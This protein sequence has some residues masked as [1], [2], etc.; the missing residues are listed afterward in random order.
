MPNK[1]NLVRQEEH[2][3]QSEA[4]AR[5][6]I[7]AAEPR[8]SSPHDEMLRTQQLSN[9]AHQEL[10]ERLSREED[11]RS[12]AVQRM[13]QAEARLRQAQL[14]LANDLHMHYMKSWSNCVNASSNKR[15]YSRGHN[16]SLKQPDAYHNKCL[17]K[18]QACQSHRGLLRRDPHCCPSPPRRQHLG[19]VVA[20]FTVVCRF[21]VVKF[22]DLL[23]ALK[24]SD[25]KQWRS[26]EAAAPGQGQR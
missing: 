22:A 4:E 10:H 14:N 3:A 2:T 17:N 20:D 16:K 21:F 7:L 9:V 12:K 15:R 19:T 24:D 1:I 11:A 25:W 18:H 26:V 8:V 13:E 6:A 23:L 5:S